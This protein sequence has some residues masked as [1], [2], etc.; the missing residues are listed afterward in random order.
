MVADHGEEDGFAVEDPRDGAAGGWRAFVRGAVGELAATGV[1]LRGA[2]LEIDGDVPQGA[3]LSSSAAALEAALCLALL[4]VAEAPS[5]PD[6]RDLARLCSRI[7]NDW[8]GAETGLALD[9]MALALRPGGSRV[10]ARLPRPGDR[11]VP[12]RP[13]GG[14]R[15]AVVDSGEAH[16]HAEL[17]YNDRRRECAEACAALEGS[18]TGRGRGRSAAAARAAGTV[19]RATW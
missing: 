17:G 19:G 2:R 1:A 3:G 10:A 15:L 14:E 16:S 6:R 11:A 4:A 18:A 12:A 13:A 7:E 9:E 8:V 5:P